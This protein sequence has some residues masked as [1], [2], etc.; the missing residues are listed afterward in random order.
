MQF[1][2]DL[3]LRNARVHTPLDLATDP[4][5]RALIKAGIKTTNCMGKKCNNS[6]FDFQNVQ[7]YCESSGK[8]YCKLCST[9]AWVFE[10]KDS[11]IEE[12]PVCRSDDILEQFQHSEKRLVDAMDTSDFH[13]L[14]KVYKEITDAET[15]IDVKL[16]DDAKVLHLRLEKELD[17]KNF[18]TSVAHVEDY[19]T[20]RKS[21]TVLNNKFKDA[22]K[23]GVKVDEDLVSKINECS[24]RLISERNLRFEMENMYV[25]AATKDTVEKL[26]GLIELATDYSVE[27]KY[28]S[29]ANNLCGKMNDN[30]VAR[31]TLQLLLDYPIR[32]YPEPEPLDAK[33]KPI[34]TKDDKKKPKKRKKKEPAFP[35]PDWAG[36]I[37]EVQKTVKKISDLA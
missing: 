20:I 21:V 10:N 2:V 4:E 15:D 5:T 9:K 29:A 36:S 11:K 32:E 13:T 8:F 28:M 30:I 23:L 35:T 3:N 18:I 1:G 16:L 12:R 26:Q 7:F 25:S 37:E 27:D 6:K 34:K 19:K 24:R 17:I 33:G 31:E 22:E 14:D